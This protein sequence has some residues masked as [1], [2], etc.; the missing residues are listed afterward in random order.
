MDNPYIVKTKGH[1]A[2]RPYMVVFT[3]RKY[4]KITGVYASKKSAQNRANTLNRLYNLD[5]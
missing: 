1:E 4:N 5:R 2:T 3:L